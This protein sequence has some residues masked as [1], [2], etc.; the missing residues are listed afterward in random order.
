LGKFL[1][2]QIRNDPNVSQRFT[3][4][5]I[6]NRSID[7]LHNDKDIPKNLILENI[8]NFQAY[9]P[10]LIVEVADP[11]ITVHYGPLFVHHCDYMIGLP[12]VF[13][14]QE[15]ENSLREAARNSAG[16]G[17][18]IPRGALWGVFDIEA[19]AQRG[20]LTGLSV[21]MKFH[22]SSLKLVGSL[23]EKLD[24]INHLEGEQIL[25]EGPVRPLCALAP[26]NVNTIACAAL[27]GF[28][29]GFDK[30]QARLISDKDLHAHV[31]EI[32]VFGPDRGNLG[33]F[34]VT[35]QRINPAQPGAV[36]GAATYIS[37]LSSLMGA[38]GRG[39]GFHFC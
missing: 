23:K 33:Q 10:E 36:T 17:V 39:C 4:A 20:T 1:V 27:A 29:I 35:T 6:W 2:Q 24:S 26:N 8:I 34:K 16:N 5:F 21:T 11:S 15:L 7:K 14:N 18:Y 12:T 19:M 22:P 37:F 28:T 32:T 25:Y 38:G 31:I 13:A 9:Q 3:L 30:T